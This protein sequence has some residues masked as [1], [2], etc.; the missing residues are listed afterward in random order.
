MNKFIPDELW[1]QFPSSAV[2]N[3]RMYIRRMLER[4]QKKPSSF[5]ARMIENLTG[6]CIDIEDEDLL[7]DERPKGDYS[8]IESDPTNRDPY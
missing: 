4:F 5:M 8:Q 3:S 6:A 1:T 7:W 2:N